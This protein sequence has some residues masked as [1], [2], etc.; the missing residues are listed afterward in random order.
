MT[1]HR[2]KV[3][4]DWWGRAHK[5]VRKEDR[6]GFNSLVI[7]SSWTLWKHHNTGVFDRVQPCINTIIREFENEKHLWV[8]AGARSLG[9]LA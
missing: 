4:A 5:Q 8:L 3:F 6:K 9:A 1:S 2:E 7:L